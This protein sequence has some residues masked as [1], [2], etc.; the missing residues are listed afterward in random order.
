VHLFIIVKGEFMDKDLLEQLYRTMLT[1]RRF[2]ER[3][4]ALSQ[5]NAIPG[6]AHT[7]FGSEAVGTGVMAALETSDWI[8]STYRCHGHAIAKGVD[9][10]AMAA[11]IYGRKTG[12]CKGKGGSM[13]ISDFDKGMLGSFGIVA[14]GIPVAVGAAL[15]AKILG[16]KDIAVAFFGDGAVHQGV[17]HEGAGL[18]KLWKVPALLVCENNGYAEATATDY[19]LNTKTI[20]DMACAYNMPAE[21]ADGMDVVTVYETAKRAVERLRK[22]DGPMLLEFLSYRFSG[23]YEGDPQTYQP[24]EEMA[25]ARKRDPLKL[26]KEK[27]A[28]RGLDISRLATIESEVET[29]VTEAFTYAE[30]QPFPHPEETLEDVYVSYGKRG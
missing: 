19:H 23:Q 12:V 29:S 11:E 21:R 26:F 6:Y 22:G 15:S 14:A 24:A 30:T 27:A 18:A 4:Q 2:D 20:A 5:A 16:R 8:T 28:E 7:Y 10:K 3:I 17:F 13:H 25:E 9:L 1:M